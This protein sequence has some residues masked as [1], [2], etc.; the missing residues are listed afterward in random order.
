MYFCT[1][2]LRYPQVNVY[3]DGVPSLKVLCG[4]A[5]RSQHYVFYNQKKRDPNGTESKKS[6]GINF[7]VLLFR[8][9]SIKSE[10]RIAF[11]HN[12]IL[13]SSLL[14]HT[15]TQKIHLISVLRIM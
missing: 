10:E 13:H 8:L 14:S 9:L 7:I 11:E 1:V 3:T 12:I 4:R 15:N 2:V 6:S 5:H